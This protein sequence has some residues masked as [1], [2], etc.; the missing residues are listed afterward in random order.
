VEVTG[1]ARFGPRRDVPVLLVAPL[2]G[3]RDLH[4]ALMDALAAAGVDLAHAT[5]VRA[6]FTPHVSLPRRDAGPAPL[7]PG[8]PLVVDHVA[9]LRRGDGT[10]VVARIP[11]G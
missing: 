3:L 4:E 7:A 2:E 5:H 11:F 10:V 1:S 6:G 8:H 9:L